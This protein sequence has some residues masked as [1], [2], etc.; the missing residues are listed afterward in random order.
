MLLHLKT[1]K[2]NVENF[3]TVGIFPLKHHRWPPTVKNKKGGGSGKT[4]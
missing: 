3:N 1:Q 2:M 4:F